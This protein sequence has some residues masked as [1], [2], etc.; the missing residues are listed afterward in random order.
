VVFRPQL[1]EELEPLARLG[2]VRVEG[3]VERV[4]RKESG[5]VG[6]EAERPQVQ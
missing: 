2:G 6:E 5:R 4:V 3:K 1:I